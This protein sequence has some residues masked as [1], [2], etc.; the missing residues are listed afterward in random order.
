VLH[1]L[2]FFHLIFTRSASHPLNESPQRILL[3]FKHK[4]R[5]SFSCFPQ[6]AKHIPCFQHHF[7]WFWNIVNIVRKHIGFELLMALESAV[8]FGGTIPQLGLKDLGCKPS[9][10]GLNWINGSERVCK[11]MRSGGISGFSAC[12]SI[13]SVEDENKSKRETKLQRVVD[14]TNNDVSR[15]LQKDLSSL[16][17]GLF[18]SI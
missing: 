9:G 15:R 18:Y 7:S 17:S 12:R 6:H 11:W 2:N 14:Q 5:F 3:L 10:F 13:R 8:V 1:N 4:L 16:P